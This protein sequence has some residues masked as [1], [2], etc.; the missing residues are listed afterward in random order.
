[1]STIAMVGSASSAWS[2]LSSSRAS[3]M[4]EKLFAKVDS[5]GNGGVDGSELQAM[6]DK[7]SERTGQSLGSADELLG[8]MDSNGD[9]S[10]DADELD[11]GMKSLMPPP[12][13]TM[14]FAGQRAGGSGGPQG[15]HGGP[16]PGPPPTQATD[17]EGS[18]TSSSSSA[19]TDPLD[20]NG[21]GTV[22]AQE[23]ATA[24]LQQLTQ[25]LREA[26]SQTVDKNQSSAMTPGSLSVAA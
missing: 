4:K 15:G 9:G 13:S 21:D 26:Y 3:A 10:L 1:M 2:D 25:L 24:A 23:R 17:E 5:D 16:P 18:S 12:S 22:S 19:S 11:S 8:K 14:Q 20:L 6:L 7:M